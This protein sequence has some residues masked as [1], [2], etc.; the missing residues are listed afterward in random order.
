MRTV[1]DAGVRSPAAD[2]G[3]EPGVDGPPAGIPFPGLPV[4]LPGDPGQVPHGPAYVDQVLLPAPLDQNMLITA[5][6]GAHRSEL[7]DDPP[8]AGR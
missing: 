5:P 3:L 2:P 6:L 4:L 1:P 7:P 8:A